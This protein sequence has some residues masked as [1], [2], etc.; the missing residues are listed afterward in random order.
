MFFPGFVPGPGLSAA[1]RLIR[2]GLVG[3]AALLISGLVVAEVAAQQSSVTL[4]VAPGSL[5]ENA[6]STDVT[7]TATL[8]GPQATPTTVVLSLAGT[9]NRGTDYTA[10]AVPPSITIPAGSTAETANLVVSPVDDN[11]WEGDESIEVN[12]SAGDLVVTGASLTLEDNEERPDIRL[13]MISWDRGE[14]YRFDFA[15]VNEIYTDTGT[16]TFTIAV[17]LDGGVTLETPLE[18]ALS[19]SSISTGTEGTNYTVEMPATTILPAGGTSTNVEVKITN[20][21][22]IIRGGRSSL[23]VYLTA[24]ARHLDEELTVIPGNLQMAR[25]AYSPEN[26]QFPSRRDAYLRIANDGVHHIYE[27]AGDTVLTFNLIIEGPPPLGVDVTFDMVMHSNNAIEVVGELPSVVIDGAATRLTVPMTVTVRPKAGLDLASIREVSF[28]ASPRAP[29]TDDFDESGSIIEIVPVDDA[30]VTR[31]Y[32][33]GSSSF[34]PADVFNQGERIT[35]IVHFNRSITF[36]GPPGL[37]FYL[38]DGSTRTATCE[39]AT[40]NGNFSCYYY[41]ANGDLDID[42]IEI[43][44]DSLRVPAGGVRDYFDR[45]IVVPLDSAI[46]AGLVGKYPDIK[47]HGGIVGY[48]LSTDRESLQEGVGRTVVRVT[49]T[50]RSGRVLAERIVIPL[51]IAGGTATSADYVVSGDQSITV[52]AGELSGST[53]LYVTPVEDFV[54]EA[55]TESVRIAG[56]ESVFYVQGTE[57]HIIDAPSIVLSVSGATLTEQGGAQVVTVTAALGDPSDSTRPRAIPVRLAFGGTAGGDDYVVSGGPEL[58]IPANARSVSKTLTFTPTDDRLLEGDET[59]VLRG[60]TPGL[61]VSGTELTIKDDEIV[62]EVRLMV[63]NDTIQES[64]TGASAVEVTAMLEPDVTVG[65]DT[66]VTLSLSGTA[67]A[68]SDYTA[69]WSP[70]TRQITI[71]SGQRR[72]GPVTLSLT[73]VQDEAAEGDETV[74]VQGRAVVQDMAMGDLVVKVVSITLKD[75]DVAGVEVTPTALSV[76]EG[77]SRTY[78]VKLASRP[79]GDVTVS[80]GGYSGT[81]VS[82]SPDH[83]TF[84]PGAWNVPQMVTVRAAGDAD[85]VMDELVVLAHTV[86]GADYAGLTAPDVTVSIEETTVPTLTIE[87]AVVLESAGSAAFTVRLSAVS[88]RDVTVDYATADGTATAGSDYTAAAED[89]TLTIAAGTTE[90]TI[91]VPVTQD[92]LDEDDETFTVTLSD[93]VNATLSDSEATGTIEDDDAPPGL[94]IADQTGTEGVGEMRFTVTLSALSGRD[95]TVD[96]AT[97][98]GTATAGSDYTA[99]LSGATLTIAAGATTGTITVPVTQDALD[100]DDETFTVTLSDAVNATLSDSEASGTIEDDDAVMSTLSIADQTGPESVGSLTFTVTLSALSGRDVTVGYTTTDGTATAGS[101]YTASLSGAT[102]TIAAG[103]TEQTI[104]VPVTQDAL[105][106]DD[107]T[108]TVTLSNPVNATLSD[109]GA[110]GTIEDDDAPTGLS[111]ADQTGTEGVG[112][113]TFTVTLSAV[114]GRDVTVGYSTSDGT[115]V[116]GSDYVAS[117]SGATL[118]IPAG[119]TTGTIT[120]PVT[121]DALDEDDETFTVTLSDAVNATLSDSEATGTIEDDDAVMSTLSIADRTGSESVGNLVF[122]VTLSALSGRDVTV[123]YATADVTATAGSDYTTA[124]ATLTIAAGATTGTITV[125]VTQDALDEADN[126]TFKVTLSNPVNATLSDGEATGTIEDDDEVT[127]TLSIADRTGSESVGSLVFTVT[128][129]AVSGRDVTVEYTTA[130]GTA[131]AGSD[132][133]AASGATLTIAAGTTEQTIRVPVTPDALDEADNETF[134]VTLSNPVNATLSDGE[135]TGTITDDDAPPGLSIADR[136]GSESTGSLSFTVRLSAVS[137]RDVTVKYSTSD[138]TATAGSDYTAAAEDAVLTISAGTLTGMIVVLIEPDEFDEADTE[139]FMVTLSDAVN[140]AL[141]DGEA[142]GTITDDDAPP[143][144]SI[145]DGQAAEGDRSLSFTVTLSAV[146]ERDVTVG[147]ATS[148]GTATAGSDYTAAAEDAVLTISAGTTTGTITVPVTQDALDEDNE[149]FTVTLS[150]PVNATVSDGEASGT[151]RDDDGRGIRLNL[152]ALTVPEGQSNNNFGIAL[153]SEPTD[154][155]TVTVTAPADSD[156]WLAVPGGT[157]KKLDLTFTRTDWRFT[158]TVAPFAAEDD[159]AVDDAPVRLSYTASGGDYNGVTTSGPLITILEDDSPEVSIADRTGTESVGSLSFEVTLNVPSSKSVMV[160]YGT[161]DGTATAGTDYTASANATLTFAALETTAL[162][163]I[164]ITADTVDEEDNETFTVTLSNPVNATLSDHEA[165]GTITD[166][167]APPGLSIADGQ[168]A[169][170]D[171]SLSFTVTLSAVS[172]RDVTVGYATADGTAT[173]GTDYTASASGATL[174]ISAGMTTGTITVPVTQDALDEDDETFTVTLSDPVNATLV[175]HEA[176][177]TITDD[178]AL[179][180]LSIADRTESE[181]VG[182]LTFTVTLSAVSGR[183]VTVGYATADGTATAGTDYTASASGATL[184][185]SAGMTTGTITV[186]VTQDALDEDDETFKVTLSNPVNATLSDHEATGTIEDDDAPPGLSIADQTGSEDVGSLT[187]TVTLSAVSGRDVTVT[188]GTAN[189]TATAGTDYTASASGATLAIPA[190]ATTGTIAVPVTQDVLDEADETF[191]VTL[192]NPVNATLVDGEATG[193][194]TD[195]DAPPGLSIAD[196][197]ESEGVGDMTFTVTLSAVSG[198]DVTVTYGTANGT[199]T[200]GTDYTASVGATL[201]IAAGMTTGT[202]PV[203]VTQDVLD[204]LD[205]TFKVT[206]SNPVNATLSDGEAT[207]TIEDDDAPPGLSI[208]DQTESEGVGD[209]TFTVTLSAVSGR[210]VTVTY[211]TS[212]VTATAGTDYTASVGATLTIAAG[213]TTGTIPVPVTQDVLD[214]L[215]ETFKVTLSNPVNATLSDGEATGTITDDDAPPGLSVA[216]QTGS[217]DVGSLTFTVTLSAVSGRD[218]TVTYGTANGTATAGTD[219]TATANATLTIPAGTTTGTIRVPVTQDALDEDDETFKVTL[220]GAANAT[221]VDGE[222]TGTITDDDAP[223]GLSVADQTGSESVGN[224]S[225]TVTLSAVSG[226]DVTVTYVTS[227][228]TATAGT[229][230]TASANATLTI[231]AGSRTR[232]IAVP[233]TQDMLDELDETF[234]VT[235]SNPVNVT[236]VDGEATGTIED[237]DAPPGLSIADQT[238]TE[239]V[240]DMVFTVT[241]SAVSGRDVTVDYAT[242]DG[243]ATAGSDYT[244]ANATLTIAAGVTTGT[245][246]VPVTQDALDEDDETFTVALSDAVNATLSDS[247]ATGTIEDD[248]APPGLS[249]ADQTESE[250]VGDMS[251][252]VTLDAPSSKQV[253]VTYATAD[254]TATAGLDYTASLS[255]ATLTIAAGATTGT[256]TVPV[257]QDALDEDDETFTVTLSDAV[258]ATLSDSEATGTIEDDDAPPGLSIADQTESEG[259]GDMSFTVTLDAPSSKQVT[260]TYATADVTATAGLDYTASLSGATL[261]IPAGT[262]TGTITVPVT[263]DALDEDDETFTVTL[264]DAVNATLSDSEATGTIEDDDAPPGLSIADQTESEGVGDMSFT[265]TLD[266][267]SSKQVT[268]TYATAD[269]TAT[270]GLDYTASLS[271]ATLTIPAGTTTGT[272]TVPVTQDALDEDDETFTVTLSDAVNAT[273]SD[274]EAT[275]TIEDDDA[276]PGLSIA[277]QTGT[278]G[279]GDMRFTV[280][281][282]ALSGRD[283]TVK[284]STADGTATAGSD[285]TAANATLTIAA[286][287]TTGLI[288]VP[289]TQ[290]GLDEDDETFTVALSDAVNATLS[291]SEASGTIEDDDAVMSTLSIADQTGSESVGNLVFTVTLSALSGRDVTVDYATADVTATAGSDYTAANATLTIAAGTTTGTIT[292]PVTQDGLDEADTE[293]F[294]VTL[295]NPGNATLL[296]SEAIGT[297]ED[298]DETLMIIDLADASVAENTAYTSMPAVTGA[299]SAVTWT[300]EGTD[301]GDFTIHADTGVLGMVGRDFENPVDADEDNDYEVTVRATDAY[302]NTA[303]QA[304]TVTVTDVVETSTL[305]ISGLADGTVAENAV[306]TSAT[307]TVTGALGAVTWT[308]EGTDAGDFTIN[309]TTGVLGMVGRDFE[310]PADADE[311]NDYEVTVKVEDADGNTATQALTVTVT[312]VVET[313]TLTISGLAD[314]TVAENAVYTSARPTVTGAIGAV[315]WTR[316]GTDEGDFTINGT[317]GVLSMVGRDFES[318]ADADEDNDYEV[319]VKV[320]DADGNTAMQALTVTVTDVVETSTLTISGLADGSVAEN[321]VYTSATPTVTGALG[322]VTWTREGVDAGDFTINA[323]TGVLGMVGRDFE[324]P[325][326]ADEDND[327]EVT[328]KVEDADGNTATQSLTVT[329]TDVVETSTL[330]ISGLADGTVAE[331]AV[332]TSATPTVTGALGAVTWTKEGTDADDFTINADT[333]VLG[334]V[335][336]DFESPADADEDNDYEVTVKVED[337]DGNTATQALTVTV[338]D[339]VETSTL[340]I[341]GLADGTVAENAVY[342]SATPTVTGALGAVT[343]TR[344]GTDA[345]DFTINGTTGVLGMVGRDFESPADADEDNDYEV[346]VKVEDADGNT[347][348]QALTVTV[349]DVVETSTLTISGLADGTVA[350]NAVYTSATPTVTGALGAVTWTREGTDA[351]DFTINADTGVLGMVGRD[352]ENPADAD[353]DNDY[354][355][356]VK[357]EDADGNTATQALTVTVTDVVETSTLTISGLADGTVAENAVYTS[358]TPTV[359]GALGA[360]TWTREGTDAGDFTINGTTGVLGMVGRD[361]ESPA[362]AD[363]DNDYQVTVKVEDAD[364]N[365][366]TQALTVTVTDVVETSTLTISGLADGTVAENAVYT[367]ATPTVTGALGAVTWTREGTDAGDFTINADTGVLGMVGRDFENPADA[368]EDNDYEVTVKVEDA[369]GN[370]ATQALTVTV[371]DVVETA[372]LTISGLADGT[373]AEN[374]VYTSATPTVTGA[375]GAVTWTREGTDA[376]DFTINADTGVLGMVGRDFE[377][378]ADADE[379]NDYQVTVKVED[380]DGNTAMQALTVTVTDVVETATLT[381]SGLADGT[382][383]ENAVYTSATPT[384]TGALGAVTWTKEGTDADDFTINADTGVLGMVGRDFENPADADKDNDYEVTVKVEDA[385]GNT[386]TQALTVTVTDVVETATLTISG[387]ADGTVAENAVYTSATPTVT[388]ALGAVTWTREGTD[389]GDFTINADTGVL[390]MV[391]RDFESPADA[392]EDND[393]E[394]TVKVEDADGNTA[395]QALTV[396]VT[397]VVETATLTISGLADGTVAENAVYTSARPTVTGAIGAVTWTREGVDEGDF[398]IDANTGVLSMAPR[399]FESRE[400]ADEDNVYAVT[401]RARDANNNTATQSLTVTVTDVREPPAMPA[402]PTL[403]SATSASLTVS[404]TAP[405]NAGRPAITSY[406][407]RYRAGATGAFIDGPQDQAG[408]SATISGLAASTTYQVQVRASNDEGDSGWSPTLSA[409]TGAASANTAPVFNEGTSATRRVAENTAA[410]Q[411]IGDPLT[412]TDA[413]NDTLTY[414]LEGTDAAAFDIVATTGQIRTRVALDYEAKSSYSVTVTADDGNGGAD[415]IA[416]TITITDVNEARGTPPAAPTGLGVLTSS[417]AVELFWDLPTDAGIRHEVRYRQAGA[418]TF[419]EWRG[420][421]G[422]WA[423]VVNGVPGQGLENGVAY[424][425]EVRAVNASGAGLA[426]DVTATPRAGAVLTAPRS[427]HVTREGDGEVTLSWQPPASARDLPVNY[428]QYRY[429]KASDADGFNDWRYLSWLTVPFTKYYL[430]NGVAYRFEVRAMDGVVPGGG[431]GPVAAVTATPRGSAQTATLT[432]SGLADG[433]VAE[434]AVYTSA[435]PTV[436]GAIGAVTWTREGVDEGDF[437]I[438]ANTGVLSMAPRNFESREDADEDNVYAVTVRARDANNNTATQSLTVT[439]T[440]VREP[441]A[442]PAMPTLDSATSASLT[443]SWTAPANAGRPAITSY[444]LRYRA[445]ATGAFI[446]GPQGQAGLSA[447]ISGLAASTTYQVQ[448]RASNDEGDSGWSPT[449]SASTGAASANTAP[450]FNEG[451]SAT[452]RVAENT[453]TNQPFGDPVTATDADGDTLTYTLEGTDAAAF[454][455]VATTGQIRTRVA[456]DYEAKSSY[457]VTVKADDGNGGADTIAV[458]ITITDVNEARGTPPAAPTGLGVT[459]S[460][461]AVELFWDL[462]TDAGIRHEVRYR[463]AGAAT[464]GEWRGAGGAWAHVV[465]GVPGQGLENGVAYRFEVRAVNASGAGLAVDVTATPRAGAVLTAPRSFH[466]AR[467]GDGEVT[468][469]WQPPASARDLPVNYYQYRYRKASD[470]DGFNDWRYL[471]WLTVPFTKYYLDN[472]VAYRFEVRAMDGVVPGGGHGPVAAVTATPRGSAQSAEQRVEESAP[473]VEAPRPSVSIADAEAREGVDATID[474]LVTLRPASDRRVTVDYET[475]DGTAKAGEDYQAASG[476]LTFVPGDTEKTI[477]VTVLDDA[478]DEGEETFT[479]GLFVLSPHA[480]FADREA[481][482]TIVNSDPVPQAWLARFGRTAASQVV[483]AVGERL[484]GGS[485]GSRV[486][487]AGQRLP[488]GAEE[489]EAPAAAWDGRLG[490]EG[491]REGWIGDDGLVGGRRA[492]RFRTLT[493]RDLLLGSSFSLPLGGDGSAGARW[494]AWGGAAGARFDGKDGDLLLDGDVVTGTLGFD[495][496]WGRWLAGVAVSHSTGDGDFSMSGTCA[497][498]RCK[499]G[500]ESTVTGVHPYVRYEV[501]EGLTAW[502]VLGYGRGKL[503]L[504]EDGAGGSSYRTDADLVMGA[505][506]GRGVLLSAGGFELAARTDALLTRMRSEAVE[507]AAG[508]LAES[509]A[510]TS[511][512]RLVLEGSRGFGLGSGGVL[513]PSLEVGVRYDGGDAETGAGVEVGAGV[514]YTDPALGLSMEA[515]VHGLMAHETGGYE[516]W[517]ASGSLRLG[518]DESGRGLSLWLR[519]SWGAA[520]S[521]VER[522]WSLRDA[523]D[524]TANDEFDQTGRLDAELGYGVAGPDG[525][526]VV[527][528][529]AGFGLSEAGDRSWRLGTRWKLGQDATLELEGTRREPADDDAPTHGVMLRARFRW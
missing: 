52:R 130:D 189:G 283:V 404:W 178:D 33:T 488:L 373:V 326:D 107:E 462:P 281:L 422:A 248:D 54:K 426:V 191:K 516:E 498:T 441:P 330:T 510:D 26:R 355:V 513:T 478:K 312:D 399:N 236:V 351:G 297:I 142:T 492:E 427:F 249:I 223:P 6:G 372:T 458:T 343:W 279:V 109:G 323:D 521:G 65:G 329:V 456:L 278:E 256:I 19:L 482:G 244:A 423:H 91:T 409:S 170:G 63:S 75:D 1:R 217:E 435:R 479:L 264:S 98:D 56:G 367:S 437:T 287:T 376:D 14:N 519:P 211:G 520:S 342:T 308:R 38:D 341:S 461:A 501:K 524:L 226:R 301:A 412:A 511:R 172:D 324:N 57:F 327:Y 122:T 50:H 28:Y 49:A 485:S 100:E 348:T 27:T 424:R 135:A 16:V 163:E 45:T 506:G 209:M 396:T 484:R 145:A 471:S 331:N 3:L 153:L 23:V 47:L 251:F 39:S 185:I 103:T 44:R 385:D 361:F 166:D 416:V 124:N 470:A 346:T 155:V 46:P 295:G 268:V 11:F 515:K 101:D 333:G 188:Y 282:S 31:L 432:I 322:A 290:D 121:Q 265:V 205:E 13:R 405:A 76:P 133:T 389:A 481:T 151:I 120:V 157:V 20:L 529:Y 349:T 253:T 302:T 317:T 213:M 467:E 227:D 108:F 353:E 523:A 528:P 165:T 74:V 37:A 340:T 252:T 318:P 55:R 228:G 359:T 246:T 206:L 73:P 30:S 408:L 466:V 94:S 350:E 469:S 508:R 332:Y 139:T 468:L 77:A 68:G 275:G 258:N 370:T 293:T 430:D 148:D 448:V 480:K 270:A 303:T 489:A 394:V 410:G 212:D 439:V 254:V 18:V 321:A 119:T 160:R 440:D 472:G 443:V 459:T 514:R 499:G 460:S 161:S 393:Y 240:G 263:Q 150:N 500:V 311:D 81:D 347:A 446:D 17:Q 105:D 180:G 62:P 128:L 434:N 320:E 171:G 476:T 245:I 438:D 114:S 444:D 260:V 380:A 127:S 315:T 118:T 433:T 220:S 72:G 512:L 487:I 64:G 375:L 144:L 229:D 78:T 299:S 363:E 503:T 79:A 10:P 215:D 366:A 199:A 5:M 92:A 289:V 335:G 42:G 387:L 325:A 190:G 224:L 415:T 110:S 183:D 360:V 291:D 233:V 497:G 292:V 277:D 421:G 338:T 195:D 203:P 43:R 174:T 300:V 336:R 307:P 207:G 218:V 451:T 67:A 388:G 22:D 378:P 463:Q 276:P 84:T 313:A 182:D 204:E 87:D 495:G 184:T 354:E 306:Y 504:T 8:S 51:A 106:E 339:V 117:L 272:I 113:M 24:T 493:G 197:T 137:G 187:F 369:D 526:G 177:G 146:S 285:Y 96:Y 474:F 356:T 7:V 267:P 234:K 196:Q 274:S 129:S 358:A 138:G 80:V 381:I 194:I 286:G 147:Y 210:D 310:S 131:T 280:T 522:L 383:A 4:T 181:G 436:T 400:D 243:T 159:D 238:G 266:A 169:E 395:T 58:T 186:P 309:G 125:P 507:T 104:T 102:L 15:G 475:A 167:D 93:A 193:T 89:A 344:E 464:F 509:E 34:F 473:P 334:M 401:V 483:E 235:L 442:M 176:T 418:A 12:G 450:V 525:V 88:S 273:L 455:I 111:V 126:E 517:G 420:A 116:A 419:G 414:T 490:G 465:N 390:G 362:D 397:D 411:A 345:G 83:L 247:E 239:G 2:S 494:T 230:Y 232:T 141:V 168:A 262:T 202:I 259:V 304:L 384:V 219:Y 298:D 241:L 457:S 453:A 428:Y 35:I 447:T 337:A 374:A 261:T 269:V 425:F 237:D 231:P 271:G 25:I 328:V 136:T 214:E 112:E 66:V 134:K 386:A 201:T 156:V 61:T 391:G 477:R 518:P 527:T 154:T 316:E 225:F 452:R 29:H 491:R 175:D 99:S 431:H 198:R 417:A 403:D 429:R 505:L 71:P 392:D 123:D 200:A 242:A 398:T 257:T 48:E 319:T 192:S 496:E 85:A 357:V 164:P 152:T 379:D 407:L 97:A 208:A 406:D 173:A 371:T 502:A 294:K 382:V 413:D 449:L 140:A 364:G 69:A 255:G 143:G 82:V 86:G 365:T 352:F 41:V 132:Y 115:A 32:L 314:G 221:V 250:G 454:D 90:Q 222:A 40:P 70:T 95:V 60:S 158:Q 53:T 36:P 486:T 305:T 162:I 284:Y 21:N 288:T 377:N 445:G 402:M 149:T 368:D 179:P 216:D 296:D 59:I 9:A